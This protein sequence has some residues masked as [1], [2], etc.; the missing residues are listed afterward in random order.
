MGPDNPS[1]GYRNRRSRKQGEIVN[2]TIA[3][4]LGRVDATGDSRK[5]KDVAFDSRLSYNYSS[6]NRI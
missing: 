2:M 5:E 6:H 4:K 1:L 3:S